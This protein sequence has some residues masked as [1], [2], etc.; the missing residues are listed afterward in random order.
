[1]FCNKKNCCTFVV[2]KGA[3]CCPRDTRQSFCLYT[4]TRV[5]VLCK[6][7]NITTCVFIALAKSDKYYYCD[8]L[9]KSF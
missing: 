1:M 5:W 4:I 9:D 2:S 3:K 6:Y 8:K 7:F